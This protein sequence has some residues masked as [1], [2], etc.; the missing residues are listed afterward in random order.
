[1]AELV[2]QQTDLKTS[3]GRDIYKTDK[4][5]LNAKHKDST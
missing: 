5:E 3:V 4:G 1:M 2:G